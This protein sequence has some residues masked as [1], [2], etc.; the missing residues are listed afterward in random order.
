MQAMP[1]IPTAIWCWYC[2]AMYRDR[3]GMPPPAR[4]R[5]RQ[6]RGGL[7]SAILD[8]PRATDASFATRTAAFDRS[9][10]TRT[11]TLRSCKFARS[12]RI[13]RARRR[14]CEYGWRPRKD[15]SQREYYLT[16]VVPLPFWE[17]AVSAVRA[18]DAAQ[19]MGVNDKIQ[20]RKSRRPI[21]RSARELMGPAR[22]WPIARLDVRGDVEVGRDVFIISM[23]CWSATFI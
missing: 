18:A 14:P 4:R 20:L 5:G 13:H 9:S 8:D 11:Q 15:N 21:G 23:Q 19:V 16:D 3:C 12:I 22:R 2:M 10:S 1:V 7:L 17:V 6:R